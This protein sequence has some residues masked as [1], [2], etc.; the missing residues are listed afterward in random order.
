MKL[1]YTVY[2]I[3]FVPIDLLSLTNMS[4]VLPKVFDKKCSSR[5]CKIH[6]A[7]EGDHCCDLCRR[8]QGNYHGM[9]C[10]SFREEALNVTVSVKLSAKRTVSKPKGICL[11]KNCN[12]K[13]KNGSEYCC[14]QC[15]VQDGSC[16]DGQCTEIRK[17]FASL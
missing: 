17:I 14:F 3:R 7:A 5:G 9:N 1:I 10:L 2:F 11:T 8:T 4:R 15:M 6:V 12:F 13:S 16:H